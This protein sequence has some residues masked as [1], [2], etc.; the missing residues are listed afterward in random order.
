MNGDGVAGDRA[1]VNRSDHRSDHIS[2]NDHDNSERM[3]SPLPTAA[4]PGVDDGAPATDTGERDSRRRGRG[5]DRNRRERGADEAAPAADDAQAARSEY[6]PAYATAPA[7]ARFADEPTPPALLASVADAAMV[8]PVAP[9]TVHAALVAPSQAAAPAVAPA[10]PVAA[11][12]AAVAVAPVSVALQPA[13]PAQPFVLPLEQLNSVAETAGLQWVN[14]DAEKI[15]A[16]RAAMASEPAPARVMR[17][18]K[19]AVSLDEGPL[20]LVETRKDLSQFKLPFEV[21]DPASRPAP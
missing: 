1:S 19:P 8:E 7:T 11:V 15:R 2:D 20:V 3:A 13:A 5:R 9:A 21:A 12:T 17:E 4:T 18:A 14:S 6:A 16:A 10:A